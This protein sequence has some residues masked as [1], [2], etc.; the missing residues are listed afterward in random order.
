VEQDEVKCEFCEEIVREKDPWL[1][2]S[3]VIKHMQ[4]S[5]PDEYRRRLM[6]RKGRM[7]L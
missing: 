3:E 5:H 1:R 2:A 7:K 4:I 6:F